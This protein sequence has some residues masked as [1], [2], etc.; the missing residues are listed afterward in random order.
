[1]I[2]RLLCAAAAL[3]VVGCSPK[4][5]SEQ[6][7]PIT[8]ESAPIA[9]NPE[10]PRQVA[11]GELVFAGGLQLEAPGQA[12]F[13]GLSGLQVLPDGAF[14][15]H[16]DDGGW[17]AGRLTFDP[18]GRL[19]GVSDTRMAAMR[20]EAGKPFASKRDGDAEDLARLPDGRFAVSFEQRHR[21]LIYDLAG[22]GPDAPASVGPVL[23]A[24]EQM[25]PNEG[26]EGLAALADGTLV[27]MA[28]FPPR[29]ER[30]PV[31]IIP[32]NAVGPQA[33][34]ATTRVTQGYGV[35]ALAT[36]PN[37]DLLKMERFFL[38]LIGVRINLRHVPASS[39]KATPPQA[40]GRLIAQLE[41][42]LTLDN[43][44]GLAAVPGNDGAVRIYMISDDNFSDSQ[45]TIL[46]AFDWRPQAAIAPPPE[47]VAALP[48]SVEPPA[49]PVA[50]PPPPALTP[51][52]VAAARAAAAIDPAAPP[53]PRAKPQPQAPR[54]AAAAPRPAQPRPAPPAAAGAPPPLPPPIVVET[55]PIPGA[56]PADPKEAQGPEQ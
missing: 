10:N 32:A 54:E 11:V 41:T 53:K 45:K 14:Y 52:L 37:G 23:A 9:L 13:G 38:P 7:A 8:V 3:L 43:F 56:R 21:V 51:E 19:L 35:V 28:E 44:E 40:E 24:S 1:M 46:L 25:N 12:R 18:A 22:K 47:T 39:L 30:A 42:P 29:G 27:G 20:D 33:P 34:V 36:L 15:A 2:H 26:L 31:W 49:E 55:K 48:P 4:P 17:F 50:A 16:S 5:L 6:W